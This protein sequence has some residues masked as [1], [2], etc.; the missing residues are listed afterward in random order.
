MRFAPS[1]IAALFREPPAD[2]LD[3]AVEA[4]LEAR[5]RHDCTVSSADVRVAVLRLEVLLV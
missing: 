1:A 2:R 4:I 5:E 3:I